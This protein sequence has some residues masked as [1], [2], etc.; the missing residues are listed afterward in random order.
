MFIK[1]EK[2]SLIESELEIRENITTAREDFINNILNEFRSNNPNESYLSEELEI[3][4]KAAQKAVE[5]NLMLTN[6][7]TDFP[8]PP[9]SDKWTLPQA[10]FFA[11]T[12]CTTIGEKIYFIFCDCDGKPFPALRIRKHRASDI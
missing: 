9:K 12:V 1:L 6:V 10:I 5:G 8:F 4:E 2:P 3:Y 11:S 7:T